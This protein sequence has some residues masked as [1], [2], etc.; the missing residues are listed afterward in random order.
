MTQLRTVSSLLVIYHSVTEQIG[1]EGLLCARD[2]IPGLVN[3]A[4]PDSIPA[5][6]ECSGCHL[7]DRT[8]VEIQ[9]SCPADGHQLAVS[10]GLLGKLGALAFLG[11]TRGWCVKSSDQAS[12][13]WHSFFSPLPSHLTHTQ[14]TTSGGMLLLEMGKMKFN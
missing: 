14:S 6:K 12:Q 3:T 4:G 13:L 2:A 10:S 9:K 5:L 8:G 1:T 7:G 11:C